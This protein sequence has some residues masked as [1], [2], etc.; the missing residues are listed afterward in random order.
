MFR[1]AF[2]AIASTGHYRILEL[3]R[4]PLSMHSGVCSARASCRVATPPWRCRRGRRW[5]MCSGNQFYSRGPFRE[6]RP[7]M[8]LVADF[9][10]RWENELYGGMESLF[11]T[12]TREGMR[13]AMDVKEEDERYI[14]TADLPGMTKQDV[15]I[16]VRVSAYGYGYSF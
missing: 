14:I 11:P 12:V 4:K 9:V 15:K 13:V 8:D 6:Y 16:E 3:L 10:D 7:R 2:I 5:R 1:R